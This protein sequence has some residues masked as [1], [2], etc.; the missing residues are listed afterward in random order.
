[1]VKLRCKINTKY[2]WYC[3]LLRLRVS[4]LVKFRVSY[5]SYL[6]MLMTR[7]ISLD[8]LKLLLWMQNR[9]NRPVNANEQ[10]C[11]N[12]IDL[13]LC[14]R[15]QWHCI[16]H[17]FI[18]LWSPNHHE[19]TGGLSSEILNTWPVWLMTFSA[20]STIKKLQMP[21]HVT[22]LWIDI[23]WLWCHPS[24]EIVTTDD[25][26]LASHTRTLVSHHIQLFRKGRI[27]LDSYVDSR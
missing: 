5:G 22:V 24:H 7:S 1:M 15:C 27:H 18:L 13:Q 4:F 25:I 17:W 6:S 2:D 11:Q 12:I 16:K 21:L 3:S 10:T 26:T 14:F 19:G 9:M 23:T 20:N 8:I